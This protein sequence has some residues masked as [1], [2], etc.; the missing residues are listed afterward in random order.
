MTLAEKILA[1]VLLQ[2]ILS[3][4]AYL[5]VRTQRRTGLKACPYIVLEKDNG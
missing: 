1:G 4:G 2:K 3:V 5:Q